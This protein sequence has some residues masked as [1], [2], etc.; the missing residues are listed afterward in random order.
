MDERAVVE[1]TRI[2]EIKANKDIVDE[3]QALRDQIDEMLSA[4]ESQDRD[5]G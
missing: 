3:L 1:L 4:L 2:V 5:E